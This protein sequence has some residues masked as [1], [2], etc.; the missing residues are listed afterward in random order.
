MGLCFRYNRRGH[1]EAECPA[2]PPQMDAAIPYVDSPQYPSPMCDGGGWLQ[3]TPCGSGGY[4]SPWSFPASAIFEP[5]PWPG[6]WRQLYAYIRP[7]PPHH[8]VLYTKAK[9]VMACFGS[10]ERG[11]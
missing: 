6:E 1:N 8:A 10:S 7:A 9:H 3:E 2:A 4:T 11:E 5:F